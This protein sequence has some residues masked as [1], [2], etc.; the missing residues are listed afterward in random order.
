MTEDKL[1]LGPVP[2]CAAYVDRS[3]AK[4]S[5]TV[6]RR[7]R[8]SAYGVRRHWAHL[9]HASWERPWVPRGCPREEGM[10]EAVLDCPSPQS[11]GTPSGAGMLPLPR[12]PSPRPDGITA[13]ADLHRVGRVR[14][15]VSVCRQATND[16]KGFPVITRWVRGTSKNTGSIGCARASDPRSLI[17]AS[18]RQANAQAQVPARTANGGPL[19]GTSDQQQRKHA[20]PSAARSR[21][22]GPSS[23]EDMAA[24]RALDSGVTAR[25]IP[26]PTR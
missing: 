3:Q 4:R 15:V 23:A 5:R 22:C 26:E 12:S 18:V 1:I 21:A 6:D 7:R 2:T 10:R 20:H 14:G 19:A 16:S 9:R 25:N 17:G 13:Q 24:G 11:G 8:P